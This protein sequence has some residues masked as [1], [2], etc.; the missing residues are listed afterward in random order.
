MGYCEKSQD[1]DN[2]NKVCVTKGCK[3][4]E[5]TTYVNNKAG[6]TAD[7]KENCKLK[8]LPGVYW[9]EKQKQCN[10]PLYEYNDQYRK[11]KKFLYTIEENGSPVNQNLKTNVQHTSNH[12]CTSSDIQKENCITSEQNKDKTSF[13]CSKTETAP[14]I[15]DTPIC[16]YSDK[17][18]CC[19][20]RKLN[21]DQTA[22]EYGKFTGQVCDQN[23]YCLQ[24]INF[25]Y[26]GKNFG[27]LGTC[28]KKYCKKDEK[29]TDTTHL[30][31]SNHNCGDPYCRGTPVCEETKNEPSYAY[32]RCKPPQ[33]PYCIK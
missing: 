3:P 1:C 6:D 9:I 32:C 31:C 27:S 19:R 4:S 23:E 29:D 22:W 10:Y 18:R 15:K 25:S 33:Q 20:I 7:N 30:D 14:L 24:D 11:N 5:K 26:D 12:S 16:T 17:G 8:D 21:S 2:I 13:T 28:Y